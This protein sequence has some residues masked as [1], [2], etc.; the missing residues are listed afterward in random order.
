MASP[1]NAAQWSM[2]LLVWVNLNTKPALG[3]FQ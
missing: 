3:R 2:W 1:L